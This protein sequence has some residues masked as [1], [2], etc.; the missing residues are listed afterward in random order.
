MVLFLL[1]GFKLDGWLETRPWLMLLGAFVGM[2][3][4]FYNV[5][6]RISPPS[7]G[8]GKA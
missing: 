4:T 8:S 7:G 2:S 3:V 1:L 6:R 5:Y